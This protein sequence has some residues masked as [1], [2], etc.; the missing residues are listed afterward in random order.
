MKIGYF[1]THFPYEDCF[2]DNEYFKRYHHAGAEIAA[3]PLTFAMAQR[4]H[5]IDVFTMSIDSKDSFDKHDGVNIHR[6]GTRLRIEK[7]NLSLK[8]FQKPLDSQVDIIHAHFSTPPAELAALKYVKRKDVPL[9]LTYHG[10][11]QESF[12]S[13]IR[14]TVLSFYNKYLLDKVLL[15]ADIIIAPSEYY[16][17]ESRFLG[18]Y[19]DKIVVI[20]NGVNIEEFDLSYSKEECR[21]RLGLSVN[22]TII[23]FVGSLAPYKGPDI[24]IRAMTRVIKEVPDIKLVF[25]GSGK[26]RNELEGL[27]DKLGIENYVKFTG[28][29]GDIFK[30]ALYYRAADVFVLPS[31]S[32]SFGIVNLEAMACGVPIV[33][34]KIGGI[35]DVVKDGEN[36][37]LVPPKDERALADAI[38]YLLENDDIR[39][40]MGKNGRK[41]AEGYSWEKIAEETEEVY[42]S[43]MK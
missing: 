25:V 10:D 3:Y 20:P 5:E 1:I 42:L 2:D 13:L 18:K 34:S 15:G 19:K 21:E 39:E 4:G 11:A 7:A 31:Y 37:L 41:K 24:L 32:E 40:K 26:I 22:G 28:F 16:I 30:K 14:R 38:I 29:I 43:L 36:G 12:G 27:A 35:P 17:K 8:I 23:L 33:A 6:Y 9:I